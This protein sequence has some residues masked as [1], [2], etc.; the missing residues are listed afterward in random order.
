MKR[1]VGT[2]A[3]L[4]TAIG[5]V[6]KVVV[7]LVVT[8]FAFGTAVYLATQGR[9][10][11]AALVFFIVEPILLFVADIATGL[12][13]GLLAGVGAIAGAAVPSGRDQD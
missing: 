5:G 6:I 2:G 12:L 10:G 7:M 8:V 3:E 4:G 11:A 1:R 13:V 9:W